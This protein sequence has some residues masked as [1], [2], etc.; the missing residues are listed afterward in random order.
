MSRG[1][2]SEHTREELVDIILTQGSALLAERGY[3]GFSTRELGKRIGYSL[4]MILK[5]M[6]SANALL[7]AINTRTFDTWADALEARLAEN[8]QDRIAALVGAYFDFAEAN[9]HLWTAI[10]DHKPAD[11]QIPEDQATAR[12][13]LTRIVVNE[14]SRALPVKRMDVAPALARSL[15]ASV[16]GHCAYTLSGSF[17]LMGEEDGR[18][19][20]LA[21]V[22]ESIRCAA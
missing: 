14:V 12:S 2:R 19:A 21:R 15:I 17:A 10:F 18:G 6:G 20:A 11:Q 1:R 13:R 16:H 8:P 4:P 3:S 7:T 9:R 5:V 22:R